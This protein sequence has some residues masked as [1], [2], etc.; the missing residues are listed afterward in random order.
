MAFTIAFSGKG[1]TG[2][3]TLAALTV[4]HLCQAFGRPV[5]AVDADPNA[6]LGAA[7]GVE[8]KST[9]ADIR[10][11]AV[12]RRLKIAEG[13]SKDRQ[14]ELLIQQSIAEQP[15]FDL[16]TMG[17]PEGPKCYCYVN[18]LLRGFLDKASEDYPFVVV[19]NEA[20]MEHLSRRT[21]RDV[22][23]LIAVA[24]PTVVSLQSAKRVVDLSRQLSIAVKQRV[25]VINRASQRELT[26]A[27]QAIVADMGLELAGV[28]PHDSAIYDAST[29]GAP[30][31][32]LPDD[33]A[34]LVGLGEM[35]AKLGVK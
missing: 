35:L 9:I 1:G 32:S 3:S 20:G 10:D 13:M 27:A 26:D 6:T 34:T 11:N 17:R 28:F 30:L 14:I 19:D 4:R 22:D 21:T 5:L 25:T 8:V 24:E 18:N 23:L 16:L 12:E 29:T 2:K 31:T 33:N 7:L 15:G